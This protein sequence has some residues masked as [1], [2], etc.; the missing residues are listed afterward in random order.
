MGHMAVPEAL[1]LVQHWFGDL[2]P[3]QQEAFAATWRD[4]TVSPAALEALCAECEDV[5]SLLKGVAVLMA[6]AEASKEHDSPSCP[7]LSM[8]GKPEAG[9]EEVAEGLAA[10]S[11][12]KSL[13]ASSD[14]ESASSCDHQSSDD[15]G[16]QSQVAGCGTPEP[17]QVVD[18]GKLVS[19]G[20]TGSQSEGLTTR[21]TV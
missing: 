1:Q 18:T 5:D 2:A 6:H 14:S 17:L 3:Q 21:H 12:S 8:A 7:S 15:V 9:A 4:D 19:C 16:V 10:S 11:D 20:S 13:A